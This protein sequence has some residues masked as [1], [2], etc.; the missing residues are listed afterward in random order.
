M[1]QSRLEDEIYS[2]D[3]DDEDI[4]ENETGL[5]GKAHFLIRKLKET[6]WI[7]VEYEDDFKEYVSVPHFSYKIIQT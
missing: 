4:S 7:I 5:S 6:G 3:F 1:L 2:A